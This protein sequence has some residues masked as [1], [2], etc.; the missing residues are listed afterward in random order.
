MSATMNVK[1]DYQNQKNRMKLNKLLI[2]GF[3]LP[4]ISRNTEIIRLSTSG[5]RY[6]TRLSYKQENI[7]FYTTV[8]SKLA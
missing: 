4:E 5:T 7:S 1:N 2:P 8:V 6:H 3:F